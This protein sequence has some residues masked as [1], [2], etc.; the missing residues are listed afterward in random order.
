MDRLFADVPLKLIEQ[1]GKAP[2]KHADETSW[3]T[4]GENGYV[5]LFATEDLSIFQFGKNR[6][7][8]VPLAVFVKDPL[9]GTLVVDRN[10]G[11]NKV[12]CAIQY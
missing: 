4:I 5:W 7:C 11:Y 6:S 9:E 3:R 10:N 2:V 12:P 1:Y 8:Q